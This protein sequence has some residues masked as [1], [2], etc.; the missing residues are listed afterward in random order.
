MLEVKAVDNVAS[1]AS[2]AIISPYQQRHVS[3]Y[4]WSSPKRETK[5]LRAQS[6]DM[7]SQ[8]YFCMYSLNTQCFVQ[9]YAYFT[10][11]KVTC[12][13]YCGIRCHALVFITLEC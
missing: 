11:S 9:D 10:Y 6:K 7:V 4:T 1:A 5:A 8:Q 13:R 2:T 3:G 12:W